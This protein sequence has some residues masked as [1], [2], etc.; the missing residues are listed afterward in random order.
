MRT[1][2]AALLA[3]ALSTTAGAQGRLIPRPCPE[4][5]PPPCREGRC[6]PIR[7][8][9]A[10]NAIVRTSSQVRVEMVNRVL[11]YEV[12][13][14]FVNNGGG[15]GE[16]DYLFPLPAGSAFED[17][18]LSINGELVSGETMNATDARRIYEDIVRRQ[19]DPALV[20]WMGAG[21]L[22]AR[23]FPINPGEEKRVVVRFQSIAQREGD[24][25]RI[26]YIRGS[27]PAPN[28]P[29]SVRPA[30]SGD[31][32]FETANTFSLTYDNSRDF[33]TPFS[34]THRLFTRERSGRQVVRA[35][36]DGREVTILL[37]LRRASEAA[38]SVLTHRIDSDPGFALITIT[39][40]AATGRPTPRDL[41]FVID[42][43]GSMRGEKMEQAKAAGHAILSSLS[44]VDRF[45][46]IAF[47]T[48]V[49]SHVD[50][51]LD[52][53]PQN[54]RDA[55]RFI[56]GLHAEGSTNIS[57]ALEEALAMRTDRERL[58]LVVFLTDGE[59]TVG[60]RNPDAIA[61]IAARQR[62]DTRVFTVGVSADVNSALIER[63]AIEGRGTAHFVRAGENV[64]RPVSL[65]AS[66]L[67]NP[68]LTNVR[69]TVD[70]VRLSRV[71]PSGTVDIFA[72]QDL[73]LLARYDG[74]G[75]ANV[76]IE[77][78]SAGGR[79]SWSSRATFDRRTTR[80]AFVPRLWA[81]QR[82]GWLAAEKRR[83]GSR[84]MDGEI[85]ALGERYGIPTEF[86]SYLVLEPGMDVAQRSRRADVA[87]AVRGTVG[88][89]AGNMATAPTAAAPPPQTANEARFE[90]SRQAAAQREAK[91]LAS[92][93]AMADA[94]GVQARQVG[95]RQFV[96]QGNVWTDQRYVPT[97]RTV[98]VKAFSPLYFE[99]VNQLNGFK[100]AMSLGGEVLVSG[101]N[102]A[103]QVGTSG[104]ERMTT[105][106]VQNLVKDWQ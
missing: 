11:R 72:G 35:S 100:D 84:E 60:E 56:D 39:P 22:R 37:P 43:S 88:T 17:L 33:G 92:L 75:S 47:S 18:K 30:Q 61:A 71:Q 15:L 58:Q 34:P 65:L 82:I 44:R 16:A 105:Q 96:Q 2:F 10:N 83:T 50:G 74:D 78:Q 21:L 25:L 101:R 57:G 24:A 81:A 103:I 46:I 85:R 28:Q 91:T 54:I 6:P 70:G 104:L 31:E 69:V 19:K 36:G 40:P 52:A 79:T 9:I 86:S 29:V 20:E 90:L 77:G 32:D 66:R 26:D 3:V 97:Q 59:P 73:V 89:G 95:T 49:N 93:D 106:Q 13:E 99:L 45:R 80:N 12:D 67:T 62:G 63:L 7:T 38:V 98:Q 4:P 51:F 68:V 41:T 27:E 14:T 23:I 5:V 94:A 53:T 42:V 64:E 102:V 8:C 55:R 87:G 1:L 48:D 76:R